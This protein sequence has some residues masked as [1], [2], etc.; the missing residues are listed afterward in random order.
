MEM[1]RHIMLN[2]LIREYN[3][4]TEK[5]EDGWILIKIP[6]Y[7]WKKLKQKEENK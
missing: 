2:K 1:D 5:E 3:A 7:Q 4:E 6:F